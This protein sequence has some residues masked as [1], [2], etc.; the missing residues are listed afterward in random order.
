ME[1]DPIAIVQKPKS[2]RYAFA[3]IPRQFEASLEIKKGDIVHWKELSIGD[4]TE[5]VDGLI[6]TKIP[7]GFNPQA[8]EEKV[9]RLLEK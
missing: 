1:R 9:K 3:T 8:W 6:L 5:Y 7:T 2:K 4:S